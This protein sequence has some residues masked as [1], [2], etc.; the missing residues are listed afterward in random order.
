MCNIIASPFILEAR[1]QYQEALA[2]HEK[3]VSF[4]QG[5]IVKF[6]SKIRKFH[7][8]MLE[9]QTEICR[10]RKTYLEELGKRTGGTF[11]G[12]VVLPSIL[13]ADEELKVEGWGRCLSLVSLVSSPCFDRPKTD[14]LD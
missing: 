1:G 6:K 13:S 14:I 9:R 8:K 3:A 5:F 10:E 4:I 12:V 7:R 11:E 2:Q